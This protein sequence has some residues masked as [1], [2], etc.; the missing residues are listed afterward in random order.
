MLQMDDIRSE[1]SKI[2]ERDALDRLVGDG[3]R[4]EISSGLVVSP[5]KASSVY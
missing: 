5:S 4:L 2:G 3:G 1:G